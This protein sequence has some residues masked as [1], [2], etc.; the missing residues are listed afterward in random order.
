MSKTELKY[1]FGFTGKISLNFQSEFV[2]ELA[3]IMLTSQTSSGSA[4]S[5]L[6][7]KNGDGK[8]SWEYPEKFK[9]CCVHLRKMF[10]HDVKFT[11]IVTSS[12]EII[13]CRKAE[14]VNYLNLKCHFTNSFAE[15]VGSDIKFEV[16][17]RDGIVIYALKIRS[18]LFGIERS[19]S[20]LKVLKSIANVKSFKI[21]L[22][23]PSNEPSFQVTFADNQQLTTAFQDEAYED[24][25]QNKSTPDFQIIFDQATRK[26]KGAQLQLDK[27]T[28]DIEKLDLELHGDKTLLPKMLLVEVRSDL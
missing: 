15:L 6:P 21:T 9:Q 25:M 10:L 19:S 27:I 28:A 12:H 13:E 17:I 18:T 5:L 16:V 7:L 2:K 11:V 1:C 26:T 14:V 20:Q 8:L 3:S 24:F 4:T 22:D 23:E